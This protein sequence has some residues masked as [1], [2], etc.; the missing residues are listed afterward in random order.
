MFSIK[1]K[2]IALKIVVLAAVVSEKIEKIEFSTKIWY[3]TLV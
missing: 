3:G 1:N 2:P